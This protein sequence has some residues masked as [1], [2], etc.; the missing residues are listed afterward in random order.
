VFEGNTAAHG[1]A[2]LHMG[3]SGD[4]R[5]VGTQFDMGDQTSQVGVALAAVS[6][7]SRATSGAARDAPLIGKS[8]APDAAGVVPA[9][10]RYQSRWREMSPLRRG[11]CCS[12]QSPPAS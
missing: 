7:R 5:V 10:L 1:G 6:L 3:C 4:L 11:L 9:I 12:A 8:S 2:Q